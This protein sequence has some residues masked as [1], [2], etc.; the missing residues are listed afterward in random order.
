[1]V[2]LKQCLLRSIEEKDLN[3]V[4]KWRNSLRIREHMFTDHVIS[5]E[6]HSSWFKSLEMSRD[7]SFQIFEYKGK[8]M[9]VVQFRIQNESAYWGFYIGEAGAPKG[10]GLAMGYLAL[11]SI[12]H[13]SGVTFIFGEALQGNVPSQNFHKKLGFAEENGVKETVAERK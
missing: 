4:L 2:E 10:A 5:L 11:E 7:K 13:K 12:F 1:M 9:G 8:P 3:Q 6:E